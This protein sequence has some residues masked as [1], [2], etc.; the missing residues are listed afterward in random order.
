MPT[1]TLDSPYLRFARGLVRTLRRPAAMLRANPVNVAEATLSE[2]ERSLIRDL[3]QESAGTPGP[4][5][6]IGTL[7]GATTT[8]MALAKRAEQQIVTVDN[9]CWNPW[10]LTPDAHHALAAHALH[11]L[12]ATGHVRQVRMDKEEF[13]RTYDGPPP[14]LVFLDAWHTYEETRKD[15]AWAISANAAVIAG[16]DYCD[17]WPGVIQAVDEFGGASRLKGSVWVLPNRKGV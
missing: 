3:V 10:S 6:E 15:I 16:H 12:K 2:E 1:Q 13:F 9:F 4:I 8:H 17:L 14:A 7:V 5:I 11:Y